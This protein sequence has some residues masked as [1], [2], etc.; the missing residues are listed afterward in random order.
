MWRVSETNENLLWQQILKVLLMQILNGRRTTKELKHNEYKESILLGHFLVI[1]LVLHRNIAFIQR[2][3]V[4]KLVEKH[5]I[6]WVLRW[7]WYWWKWVFIGDVEVVTLVVIDSAGTNLDVVVLWTYFNFTVVFIFLIFPNLGIK[8]WNMLPPP[9]S[10]T[11]NTILKFR[12]T[13]L[14][15]GRAAN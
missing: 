15:I 13:S 5:G 14:V 4:L 10:E 1:V 3:V 9:A 7:Q 12:G 2:S 6:Q 8:T 11:K